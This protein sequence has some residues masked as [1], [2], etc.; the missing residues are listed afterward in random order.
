MKQSR[1]FC[2]TGS[3]PPAPGPRVSANDTLGGKTKSQ[4]GRIFGLAN[5]LGMTDAERRDVCQKVSGQRSLKSLSKNQ[6]D[7]MIREMGGTP[8]LVKYKKGEPSLRTKQLHRQK[9]NVL[10]FETQ[11][12][13][14]LIRDL[15]A[16]AGISEEGWQSISKKMNRGA[17]IPKTT[18]QGNNLIE[19][20]KSMLRRKGIDYSHLIGGGSA[21]AHGGNPTVRAGAVDTTTAANIGPIRPTASAHGG[22]P[23]VR[24]GAVDTTTAAD[25]GPNSSSGGAA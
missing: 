4:L 19:A 9:A 23:T 6:A 21:A 20:L 1:A 13:L 2:S 3:R 11:A 25:I 16:L 10:Q 5:S 12:H 8:M 17:A 24:A 14:S 18:K 15:A 22:N 7:A